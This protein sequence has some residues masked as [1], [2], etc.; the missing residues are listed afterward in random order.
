MNEWMTDVEIT[1]VVVSMSQ[2]NFFFSVD[3]VANAKRIKTCYLEE[4][5]IYMS[6]LS[7][8]F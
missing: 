5:Y 4:V 2:K 7:I 8:R 1:S 3:L 6:I